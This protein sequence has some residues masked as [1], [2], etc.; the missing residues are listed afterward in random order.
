MRCRIHFIIYLCNVQWPTE[1]E[2]SIKWMQIC[3]WQKLRRKQEQKLALHTHTLFYKIGRMTVWGNLSFIAE[4]HYVPSIKRQI[5][6]E[7]Y[8]CVNKE[9]AMCT[10]VSI[11]QM[12]TDIHMGYCHIELES[13]RLQF[14]KL[15]VTFSQHRFGLRSAHTVDCAVTAHTVAI[16]WYFMAFH[17]T[18]NIVEMIATL[19]IMR[20]G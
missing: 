14:M 18:R 13:F 1:S 9:C 17:G 2:H 10:S 7:T 11:C 12:Y 4:N 15:S 16:S 19:Q 5:T 20:E 8:V 3:T 6:G